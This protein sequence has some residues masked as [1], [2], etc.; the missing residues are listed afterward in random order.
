MVQIKDSVLRDS[1]FR[2]ASPPRIAR[3][4]IR[5]MPRGGPAW[6]GGPG[7]GSGKDVRTMLF[8]ADDNSDCQQLVNNLSRVLVCR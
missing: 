5:M 6:R 1:G 7:S 2:T 3:H 8:D 4:G